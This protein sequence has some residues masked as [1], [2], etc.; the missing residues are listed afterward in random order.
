MEVTVVSDGARTFP[1]SDAVQINVKKVD[2]NAALESASM[3]R[4]KMT[5]QYAPVVGETSWW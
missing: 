3:P 4:D 5:I 1:S 2:V